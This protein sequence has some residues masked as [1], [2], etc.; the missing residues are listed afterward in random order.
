MSLTLLKQHW[1]SSVVKKDVSSILNCYD[2]NFVFKGTF[3]KNITSDIK[4]LEKYFKNFS[5][6]IKKV[7]FLKKVK[8]I[9]NKETIIECGKYNFHTNEGAIIKASYQFVINKKDFKI[10]SHFSLL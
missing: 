2:K 6:D 1:S 8:T 7:V 3:A 10:I 5:K 9:K 4:C